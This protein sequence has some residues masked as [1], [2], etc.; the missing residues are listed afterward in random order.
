MLGLAAL[1]LTFPAP[2]APGLIDRLGAPT[3]AAREQAGR[4]LTGHGADALPALHQAARSHPDPEVR[5]R[6][7]DLAERV[8]RLTEDAARVAVPPLAIDYAAVPLAVAV[9]DLRGRTGIPLQLDE[10]VADPARPVTVRVGPLPPWQAVEAFLRAA[11][12]T[13]V[14]RAEVPAGAPPGEPLV[15]LR[16]RTPSVG[17][18]HPEA[19]AAV[20]LVLADGHVTLPGDRSGGV[21]VQAVPADFP[22]HR[23]VAG[24]GVVHLVLDVTPLPALAGGGRWEGVTAVRVRRA[25]DDHGRPVPAAAREV[26]EPELTQSVVVFG[27]AL[28]VP[29]LLNPPFGDAGGRPPSRPNPRLATVSLRPGDRPLTRLALLDGVVVGEVTVPNQPLAAV[30]DLPRAVG[31]P[32]V[33]DEVRVAVLGCATD[34]VGRTTVRLRVEA[35]NPWVFPRANRAANLLFAPN[36]QGGLLGPVG[37]PAAAYRFT[38]LAGRAVTPSGVQAGAGADDGF[39]QSTEVDFRFD[40]RPG[41]GP[42]ARL[43]VVGEK[44]VPVEV[45]FRL[46]DVPLP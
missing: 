4:E 36:F 43:V 21:R 1:A 44:T 11:G 9:A 6:A 3:L 8:G 2:P 13:E 34:P 40:P 33:G 7:A 5:R 35:P 25:E 16:H 15:R 12:L 37:N 18:F 26:M 10:S 46:R 19:P 45:P 28:A 38:D 42:P 31:A 24:A 32:T 39:R 41:S 23:V 14:V 30:E 29:G 27:G 17:V 20:P 22:G